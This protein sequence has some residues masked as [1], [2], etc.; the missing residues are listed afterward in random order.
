MN[1]EKS[2]TLGYCQ[3]RENGQITIPPETREYLS[4]EEGDTV[5]FFSNPD[6]VI[7]AKAQLTIVKP[8]K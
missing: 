3:V 8:K 7:M 1:M 5:A 4:L 2:K 6:G